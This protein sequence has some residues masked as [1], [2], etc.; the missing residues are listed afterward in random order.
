MSL[1][2]ARYAFVFRSSFLFFFFS[3]CNTAHLDLHSFPTRRSSDLA[4]HFAIHEPGLHQ[5]LHVHLEGLHAVEGA[6]LLDRK[7][8]R[9]NSSH[10][11]ISYAVFCLK[12]KT[13][14]ATKHRKCPALM[15][16][17]DVTKCTSRAAR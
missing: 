13:Q 2:F 1:L 10:L 14:R 9:L 15:K 12:K 7:S 17:F 11:G 6:S 3:P 8:T 5:L 4:T 16:F